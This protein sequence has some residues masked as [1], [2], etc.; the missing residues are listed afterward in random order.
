MEYLW[1][2]VVILIFLV[3]KGFFSGSELAMVN[4]DKIRLRHQ[5]RLGDRGAKLVLHLFRTPDVML[6][7]TLVGTNIATV[8][9]TTIGTLMF[10]RL[11][12]EVGDLISVLV[13]TPFLLIFGEIVPKSIFQ[14][15]ADWIVTK[16]I[17]GL[18]FFSF[19]FYPVIFVFSRVARVAARLFG[20]ASS[21]QIG[22]ITKDELRVLLDLSETSADGGGATNKQRIRRI[23]RFADTT[24]G[25]VMTP[26]A[27]VIGF[28]ERRVM[29]EAVRRVWEHGFNRLPVFRG[30]ITNVTGVLTL[31]TWDLLQPE[32]EQRAISDFIRP[33]LYLSPKQTID[34]VLPLLR[35][36]TDH[37]A[38]VVDEFGSAIGILTM[39]DIFE[40]VVGTI[41]TGYDFD[42][43]KPPRVVIES[44]SDD[45]HLIG[46][47]APISEL[48][49]S[50]RLNLPVGEAHTLAGFLINRL[51]HIPVVGNTVE[52]RGYRYTVI[53]ADART[54]TKVRVERL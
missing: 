10:I 48:N 18:R 40:E 13:F 46:G 3:L 30:N 21:G 5:A 6:G 29:A 45:H 49:D 28:S 32:I 4:S 1:H 22:F 38:I 44:E 50:L 14:Q 33:A 16:I 8:T 9:I 39:E 2:L 34:Q 26:L 43:M 7:T 52:E 15:K 54:V 23:F 36:R 37:M 24:V 20:G 25:E 51:R 17:Y 41:D 19:V 12:G 31:T 35:A 53:E 47:R 27:E 42:N 11:F